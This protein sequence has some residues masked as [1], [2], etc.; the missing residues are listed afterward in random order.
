MN[1]DL[2]YPEELVNKYGAKAGINMYIKSELPKI[3]QAKNIVKTPRESIDD[4]LERAEREGVGWPR[5][6]RSSAKAELWGYEG[7]FSTKEVESF[8]EF[9]KKMQGRVMYGGVSNRDA[10]N[11]DLRELI[12]SI[13]SS[14]S[15]L[16]EDNPKLHGSLP[17]KIPVIFAEKS[18][19]SIVGTYIKHPNKDDF[20]HI[21]ITNSS[22]LVPQFRNIID[23]ERSMYISNKGKVNRLTVPQIF[24]SEKYHSPNNLDFNLKKEL[25][26]VVSWHDKFVSLPELDENWAWQV[27]FGLDPIMLYQFRPFKIK[28]KADFIID[29]PNVDKPNIYMIGIT[30]KEGINVQVEKDIFNNENLSED[31]LLFY[32]KM[33]LLKNLSGGEN[34]KVNFLEESLNF[35]MHDE[36]AAMRRAELTVLDAG[37]IESWISGGKNDLLSQ[38]NWV[39]IKADGENLQ[40]TPMNKGSFPN[41]E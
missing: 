33:R 10:Y 18:D 9:E 35:L 13:E 37:N 25:E 1:C 24:G 4:A 36:V 14:S 41:L 16:K 31:P 30:P 23:P 27:E 20:Y 12:G 28:E 22:S 8:E 5:L 2:K 6:F 34:I 15:D 19:S 39:N 26:K 38:G 21:T 7:K 17:D 29:S 3:P 40:I 11:R 32:N